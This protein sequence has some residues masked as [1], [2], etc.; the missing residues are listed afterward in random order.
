MNVKA[1]PFLGAGIFKCSPEESAELAL[2]SALDHCPS[3][4]VSERRV[5]QVIN[6]C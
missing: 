1:I 6:L 3:N 5:D 2:L 4:V